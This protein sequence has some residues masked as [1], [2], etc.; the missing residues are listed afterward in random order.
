MELGALLNL[1]LGD[2]CG[3]SYNALAIDTIH[4]IFSDCLIFFTIFENG[5]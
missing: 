4:K 1:G 3:Q 2:E 5:S